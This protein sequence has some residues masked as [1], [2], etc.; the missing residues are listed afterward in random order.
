M[1]NVLRTHINDFGFSHSEISRRATK[2]NQAT[3]Y[4][5]V[6]EK[7]RIL[8]SIRSLVSLSL[9]LSQ[10]Q[11]LEFSIE[12]WGCTALNQDCTSYQIVS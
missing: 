12:K 9:C 3:T 6:E 4:R 1:S 8:L 2:L 11:M 5:V 7:L 10:M